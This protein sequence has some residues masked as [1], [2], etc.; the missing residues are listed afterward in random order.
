[1]SSFQ[2]VGIE[3]FHCIQR[4]VYLF[5]CLFYSGNKLLLEHV[6][7]ILLHNVRQTPLSITGFFLSI[8]ATEKQLKLLSTYPIILTVVTK[9]RPVMFLI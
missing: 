4:C 7:G 3:V 6:S 8:L 1:M 5:V 9:G 2:G